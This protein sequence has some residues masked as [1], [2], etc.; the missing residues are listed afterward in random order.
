MPNLASGALWIQKCT[1]FFLEYEPSPKMWIIGEG[2]GSLS[3][4]NE[5]DS[6]PHK[7]LNA[8]TQVSPL[9]HQSEVLTGALS[10]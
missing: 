3:P 5:L 6:S 2:I 4:K 9:R 7:Y 1:T 10:Q 8:P